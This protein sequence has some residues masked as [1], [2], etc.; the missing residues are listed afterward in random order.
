MKKILLLSS[1]LCAG[2]YLF[3]QVPED[4]IRMSWN[5]LSGTARNQA[6]GGAS[7]SIGGDISSLYSNPAGIGFFKRGE[8][9]ISPRLTM[10]S[11]KGQYLGNTTNSETASKFGL[12]TTG[13]VWGSSNPN[14]R[15]ANKAFSFAVNRTA[16]FSSRINYS[17]N[18]DFSSLS[19]SFAEDFSQSGQDIGAPLY[20]APVSF[21][22]KL[23]AYSYLIDTV[24][25]N[26]N[27]EVVGLPERNAI[28]A[29]QTAQLG[30]RK[31]VTSKGGI[32]EIA[33][34]YA[35]NMDDKIFLGG[36]IGIPIVNYQ[37]TTTFSETDLS[38]DKNNNFNRFDYTERYDATGVGLNARLG[39][40][41]QATRQFR[42][43]LSINS[44][45]I[46]GLRE[47]TT[48]RMETD[49]EGYLSNGRHGIANQDSIYT[50]FG[51]DVPEYRYDYVSPWKFLLSGSYLF[52]GGVEDVKQ[53]KGF[54]TADIEY[55]THRSSR[56]SPANPD[57]DPDY[58]KG[59]NDAIRIAYKGA[60]NFRAGGE[61][62]FNT[63]AARLGFSYY[64][65]PYEDSDLKGRRMNV[66]GGL[67]YRNKGI[68]A[69]LT[70]VQALSQDADFPYRLADNT[71]TYAIVKDRT[72]TLV[73]SLGF[74]F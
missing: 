70:Y 17:G 45:S 26:G 12:G 39:L 60:L 31:S 41:V 5:Q 3:A 56:F 13:V 32:T 18:N 16:N 38:G 65:S 30:Q 54:L 15:W 49:L 61:L 25:V 34:G 52:G 20:S 22:T 66:S 36:S 24:T 44:P 4:A 2:Q 50:Q 48:G 46:Y 69:D 71:N 1:A 63:I 14:S 28:L 55:V 57:D 33:F 27:T 59:V 29:G 47:T 74:K 40:I 68:Y 35:A 64:G 9:V 7:G 8:F 53:Q 51:A 19:E 6:I 43:G 23:A 21:G 11:G 72:G 58:Y 42:A 10:L 73:F 37:R 67:G 62:K